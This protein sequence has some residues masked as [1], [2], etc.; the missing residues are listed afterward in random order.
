MFQVETEITVQRRNRLKKNNVYLVRVPG[1]PKVMEV[2]DTLGLMKD[3]LWYNPEISASLVKKECCKRS[4]LR[5]VIFRCRFSE[6]P[7]E[8]LSSGNCGQQ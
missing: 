5:G 1:Q 2:L 4:F 6:R 3:G 8:Q 7:D